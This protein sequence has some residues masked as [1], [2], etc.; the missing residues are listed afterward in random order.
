MG[1]RE[2]S[3]ACARSP[4]LSDG[5]P[6]IMAMTRCTIETFPPEKRPRPVDHRGKVR[7]P[8]QACGAASATRTCD[9]PLKGPRAGSR[10]DRALCD[11]CGDTA[12]GMDVCPGHGDLVRSSAEPVDVEVAAP[13]EITKAR[14]VGRR[15]SNEPDRM[16]GGAN[17]PTASPL[18]PSRSWGPC[19]VFG[20]LPGAIFVEV[21]GNCRE[22]LPLDGLASSDDL[23]AALEHEALKTWMTKEIANHLREAIYDVVGVIVHM[24]PQARPGGGVLLNLGGVEDAGSGITE[25]VLRPDVLRR[26]RDSRY[27]SWHDR[28][29]S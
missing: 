20:N 18:T 12:N 15:S 23:V 11:S 2:R 27:G 13:T 21:G 3:C 16:V 26:L 9:F 7:G 29:R 22:A 1:R 6:N 24:R 8:C 10:C 5:P 25:R 14:T 28:R 4:S 17:G 19:C